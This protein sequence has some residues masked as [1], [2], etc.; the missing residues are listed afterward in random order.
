MSAIFP[1]CRRMLERAG[2]MLHVEIMPDDPNIPWPNSDGNGQSQVKSPLPILH[3]AGDYL[4]TGP[5]LVEHVLPIAGALTV[6]D[7]AGQALQGAP[8]HE[9][10]LGDP[11]VH[12]GILHPRCSSLHFQPVPGRFTILVLKRGLS[13]GLEPPGNI[14]RL[15]AVALVVIPELLH[16]LFARGIVRTIVPDIPAQ[17]ANCFQVLAHLEYAGSS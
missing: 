11:L 10:V 12:W 14:N 1:D 8:K 7:R 9:F 17:R 2:S 16:D 5:D 13:E 15:F 6:D 3:L 4:L